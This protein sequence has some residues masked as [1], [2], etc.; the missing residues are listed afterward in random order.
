MK[1][2]ILKI[3]AA[4]AGAEL[5]RKQFEDAEQQQKAFL[6]QVMD[7]APNLIFVK[8]WNGRYMMV[9]KA[10][11]EVYGTTVEK[12]TGKTDADFNSVQEE[13]EQYI[14][15]DQM[16]M[17]SRQQK[18]IPEEKVTEVKTGKQRWFQ[19]TKIP[20]IASNGKADH[21]LGVA[22]DITERKRIEEQIKVSLKEKEILLKE[23]HHRVKNNLQIISSLL[24]LQ[25]STIKDQKMLNMF[26]D[27][28]NRVRSM[29]LIHERLYQ[30]KVL[31]KINFSEYIDNLTKHLYRSYGI[32][33]NLVRLKT[34]VD[35]IEID[36]DSAV[37]CGLLLNELISN[38]LKHGF[39]N[40]REGSISIKLSKEKENH[41]FLT[42]KDD[43]IGLPKDL[44]VRKTQSLGLQ[45]VNTLTRQLK[46][47]MAW[48]NNGG[49]EFKFTFQY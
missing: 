40:N 13:I 18:F 22:T 37:P 30:S 14:H 15:D 23:I 35:S 7:T 21:I 42:V 25:S 28:Q 34:D 36:V 17:T 24:Y 49:T 45:L 32:N 39:P 44:D 20:L 27:S 11:A 48:K 12:L 8:D 29:A 46:G 16:V 33:M 31:S 26:K 41:F 3:F 4:R 10:A 1:K 6:R 38:S 5:E 43:G 2:T 9:N 47:T 19:T